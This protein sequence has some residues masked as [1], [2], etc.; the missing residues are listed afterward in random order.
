MR[1]SIL[2]ADSAAPFAAAPFSAGTFSRNPA[3]PCLVFSGLRRFL[4]SPRSSSLAEK[5]FTEP[6]HSSRPTAHPFQLLKR[7]VLLSHALTPR[8]HHSPPH[9]PQMSTPS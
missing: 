4:N 7:A 2:A 9:S 5:V 6:I 3:K 8:M 1:L